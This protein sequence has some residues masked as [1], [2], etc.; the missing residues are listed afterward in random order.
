MCFGKL[1]RLKRGHF[2]LQSANYLGAC[3]LNKIIVAH[4]APG[5]Q[6]YAYALTIVPQRYTITF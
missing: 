6:V 2:S 4:N 3:I 5:P 1:G